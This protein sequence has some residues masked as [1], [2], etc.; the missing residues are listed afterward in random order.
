MAVK[1]SVLTVAKNL[2]NS[3]IH[4]Q[5]DNKICL[6]VSLENGEYT[7]SRAF[8]NQQVN[9]PLSAVSWDHNYYRIFAK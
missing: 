5:M 4:I 1:F 8:K 2:S 6:I 7:Q 9:L 3:S